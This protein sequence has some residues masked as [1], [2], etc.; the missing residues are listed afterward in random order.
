M[1]LLHSLFASATL[2]II[3]VACSGEKPSGEEAEVLDPATPVS[4]VHTY[5][6]TS[7]KPVNLIWNVATAAGEEI[8]LNGKSVGS[9]ISPA[10]H[11]GKLAPEDQTINK[12]TQIYKFESTTTDFISYFQVDWNHSEGKALSYKMTA[13]RAGKV[14]FT[15][16]LTLPNE[17][18]T[19]TD[20]IGSA[21]NYSTSTRDN[22]TGINLF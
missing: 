5:E 7:E 6:I 13:T 18:Q 14:V 15:D 4:M 1:K 20:G 10:Y 16:K 8:S 11:D 19:H 9:S 3:C 22:Y 2:A 12:G 21:N 17:D